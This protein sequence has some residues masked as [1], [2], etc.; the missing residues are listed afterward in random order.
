METPEKRGPPKLLTD[1]LTE[2]HPV[3]N[4]DNCCPCCCCTKWWKNK[5]EDWTPAG[6]DVKWLLHP[7][8]ISTNHRY[9]TS[10]ILLHTKVRIWN[11][12][13]RERL[14]YP[15]HVVQIVMWTVNYMIIS[16]NISLK[17]S[18][19]TFVFVLQEVVNLFESYCK[20]LCAV[21]KTIMQWLRE[22][23]FNSRK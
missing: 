13:R 9:Y 15:C 19:K 22:G 11:G 20:Y 21:G 4:G 6:G 18:C 7:L 23:L 12:L 14:I 2:L 5:I 10:E 3:S 16:C 1:N 17:N 8:V